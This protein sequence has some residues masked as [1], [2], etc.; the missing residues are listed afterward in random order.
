[1][2]GLKLGVSFI[3]MAEYSIPAIFIYLV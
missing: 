1:L 3:S 2:Y